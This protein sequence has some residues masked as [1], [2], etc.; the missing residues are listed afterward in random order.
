MT[1]VLDGVLEHGDSLGNRGA[2][3]AGDVQWMTAGRG[4]IHRE[5][6]YRDDH[7]HT[8]QLWVNLPARKKMTATRYQDVLAGGRPQVTRP[9]TVVDVVAGPVQGVRGPAKTHWPIHGAILTLD[10]GAAYDHTL[11]QDHRLF[12]HV[13]SGDVRIAGRTVRTGQTAWVGP[14]RPR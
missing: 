2:L 12:A 10:P 3:Q 4:V 11:P 6:A 14:G 1:T 9:G 5:L 8:L 7:A 13:L